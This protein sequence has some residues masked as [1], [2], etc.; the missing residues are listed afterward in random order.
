MILSAEGRLH[1]DKI[2]AI[3]DP[4]SLVDLRCRLPRRE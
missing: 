1:A 3:A 4:P 2:D